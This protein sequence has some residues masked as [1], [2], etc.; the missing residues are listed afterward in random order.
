V[1]PITRVD[2]GMLLLDRNHFNYSIISR[3][4]VYGKRCA[5]VGL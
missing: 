3:Y 2:R 4:G 5:P 1:A